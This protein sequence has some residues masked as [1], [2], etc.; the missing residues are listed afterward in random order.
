MYSRVVSLYTGTFLEN[1]KGMKPDWT[2]EISVKDLHTD[3]R[4]D[5]QH[6]LVKIHLLVTFG[7][8]QNRLQQQ[9]E[10]VFARLSYTHIVQ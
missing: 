9:Q 10:Q 1:P 5:R 3:S 4:F 2:K 6:S 8:I 7:W